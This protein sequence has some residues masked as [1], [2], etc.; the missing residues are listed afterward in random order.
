MEDLVQSIRVLRVRTK[1]P[2]IINDSLPHA[3]FTRGTVPFAAPCEFPEVF[4]GS[5]IVWVVKARV[6]DRMNDC[7]TGLEVNGGTHE[8][9]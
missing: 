8:Q 1:V 5:P 3:V 2:G 7:Q 9:I 4:H 6:A